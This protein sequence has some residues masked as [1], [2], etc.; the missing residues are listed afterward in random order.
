MVPL[1]KEHAAAVREVG[2]LVAA[3]YANT[4]VLNTGEFLELN[5]PGAML[6]AGISRWQEHDECAKAVDVLLEVT[7]DFQ[8]ALYEFCVS[9][10][11]PIIRRRLLKKT[12]GNVCYGYPEPPK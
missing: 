9:I 8:D 7:A 2:L 4:G 3:E 10:E 6:S 1:S 5:L 12:S 11:G